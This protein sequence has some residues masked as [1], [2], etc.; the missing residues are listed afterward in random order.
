LLFVTAKAGANDGPAL[1]SFHLPAGFTIERVAGPEQLRYGMCAAFDERGR[2]FV[3]ESSGSNEPGPKLV[4]KPE[5]R[6]RLLEDRDGDGRFESSKVFADKLSLPMGVLFHRGGLF[7]A[8]PPDLL[9]F[10]DTDDDGVADKRTVLLTGWNVLNT[11]SLH[12]PFL[13]PD[14]WLYLTHGRHGYKITTKEGET[15]EGLA[16][17]IYRC[18]TDGTG[19]ER[20]CGG[21]FDNPVEL[22]FSPGGEMF[23]TMTYI[24]DPL[25]DL[26]PAGMRDA[27]I[28]VVEGATYPKYHECVKEFRLTGELMPPMLRLPR[29]APSGFLRYRGANFG[30][31]YEGTYFTNQFNAHAVKC[32]RL[33]PIGATYQASEEEFLSCDNPDFHPSDIVEDA[34]GSL[35]V[36]DTGGWYL[37][38]CSLS[39]IAKPDVKGGIYRIHRV[40]TPPVRDPR[41]LSLKLEQLE[42]AELATSFGDDRFAVRDRA[43]ELMV[44]RG[45]SA[46]EALVG[47][48]SSKEGTVRLNAVWCLGRIG[49]G[50]GRV[51]LLEAVTQAGA[52][53]RRSG[54]QLRAV[55]AVRAALAD[56]DDDVRLAATHCLGLMRDQGSIEELIR[57][58]REDSRAHVQREAATALGRIGR[59]EAAEPLLDA[60]N[61]DPEPDRFLEHA[62]AYALFSTARRS[63]LG[64]TLYERRPLARK[65]ALMAFEQVF[66]ESLKRDQVA[67]LLRINHAGLRQSV[68]WVLARHPDWAGD[69]RGDLARWAQ[70]PALADDQMGALRD[71]LVAF[72]SNREIQTLVADLLAQTKTLPKCRAMLLEV[73]GLF[74]GAKLPDAWTAQIAAALRHSLPEIRSGAV[75]TIRLRNLAQFDRE[76]LALAADGAQTIDLRLAAL[77]IVLPRQTG[78]DA[79]TFRLLIGQLGPDTPAL[80]RI[81]AADSLARAPLTDAQRRELLSPLRAGDPLITGSLLGALAQSQDAALGKQLVKT[82]VDA[83]GGGDPL[84]RERLDQLLTSY[85]AD[86]RE[87]AQSLYDQAAAAEQARVDTMQRLMPLTKG[88]NVLRG[89]EVFLSQSAAC[90]S[91]HR[92]GPEGGRIGPDLTNIGAIRAGHDLLESIIFPSASLAQGYEPYTIET[93]DGFMFEGVI[94]RQTADTVTLRTV[95]DAEVRIERRSIKNIHPSTTSIMPQGFE[96][97]LTPQQLQDLLAYLQSLK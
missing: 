43:V 27:L 93:Q 11:A 91:C 37:Q 65:A 30:K 16:S 25:V 35:L 54:P 84:P 55:A 1:S 41:G 81:S 67:A 57:L 7:V 33:T 85:P 26:N 87:A 62:L 51:A 13:G 18:R 31:E 52:A 88:G 36:I 44:G 23:C 20:I 77:A 53:L 10:D 17:R 64:I 45:E 63:E 34:D 42:P 59:R 46:V 89:R 60:L 48:M 97:A 95:A 47:L 66:P 78:V 76:L 61:A 5:C 74:P 73:I 40:D 4:E 71:A 50:E 3:T 90:G 28:H 39:R 79:A 6:I 86:V 9:R 19:L 80:L 24:V 75:A 72:S 56:A 12:G 94:I 92:I 83:P 8:S 2:L 22:V 29:V 68:L 32:H 14:G 49:M 69:I 70:D 82:L 58:L 96:Q 21:G 38:A 15:I